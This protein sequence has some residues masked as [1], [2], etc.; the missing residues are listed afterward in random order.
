MQEAQRPLS[1]GIKHRARGASV[2]VLSADTHAHTHTPRTTRQEER[3]T[4]D[5]LRLV[6]SPLVSFI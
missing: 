6:I 4:H 2:T 5:L 3:K 1:K